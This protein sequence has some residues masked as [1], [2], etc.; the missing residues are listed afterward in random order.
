MSFLGKLELE[1][2]TFTLEDCTV[3][4]SQNSDYSGKPCARPVAGKFT[5]TIAYHKEANVFAE[6]AVS[7]TM[8][9]SG[10]I[11]FFNNDAMSIMQTIAFNEAYCLDYIQN[12]HSRN[13]KTMLMQVVISAKE[14]EV[15]TAKHANN[16]PTR[17]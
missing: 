2:A 9:K 7:S 8:A 3:A 6:W 16:W 13:N 12:Y 11:Q 1:G 5:I 17:R 4:I 15:G 14:I 10:K